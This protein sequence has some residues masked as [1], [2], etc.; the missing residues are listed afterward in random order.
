MSW[1]P[2]TIAAA[3]LLWTGAA[4]AGTLDMV[5]ER[6][7]LRC[8]TTD[9]GQGLGTIEDSGRWIGFFPDICR[10]I[11]AA[12]IGSPE[13]VEFFNLSV[14]NRLEA[15]AEGAVDLLSEATTWT[16]GRD[17]NLKLTFTGLAF[18]DGQGFIV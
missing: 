7:M 12:V 14:G 1:K 2:V 3:L 15:L 16:L 17:A 11:A 18:F 9:N 4:A 10:A 5:R 6:G 13:R 8:G